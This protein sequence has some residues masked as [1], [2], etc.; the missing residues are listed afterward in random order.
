VCA[1]KMINLRKYGICTEY[2]KRVKAISVSVRVMEAERGDVR[3]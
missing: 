1:L 2:I 3:Q